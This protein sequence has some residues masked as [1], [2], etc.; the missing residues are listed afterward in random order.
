MRRPTSCGTLHPRPSTDTLP[1][2]PEMNRFCAV[3]DSA[4]SATPAPDTLLPKTLGRWL[5]ARHCS[6]QVLRAVPPRRGLCGPGH[7]VPPAVGAAPPPARPRV[8]C[9]KHRPFGRFFRSILLPFSPSDN[10]LPCGPSSVARTVHAI[11]GHDCAEHRLSVV[12]LLPLLSETAALPPA[13]RGT[14]LRAVPARHQPGEPRPYSRSPL[15]RIPTA[16]AVS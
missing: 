4:V 1:P 16:A 14:G 7:G 8:W 11:H 10:A 9:V 3:S 6:P 13:R 12:L 5:T 15:W 2:H